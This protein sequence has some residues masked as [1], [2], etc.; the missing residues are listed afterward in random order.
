[1]ADDRP[2]PTAPK[3]DVNP[4]PPPPVKPVPDKAGTET[5]QDGTKK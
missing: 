1:M 4:T 3:P 5:P 2:V